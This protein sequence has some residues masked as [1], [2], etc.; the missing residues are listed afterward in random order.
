MTY[1][2]CVLNSY[3]YPY[4]PESTPNPYIRSIDEQQTISGALRNDWGLIPQ[5]QKITQSWSGMDPTFFAQL[6]TIAAIAGTVTL[7]D[8]QGNSYSVY[9][10]PPTYDRMSAAGGLYLNVKLTMWVA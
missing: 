2:Q 8:D 6:N 7:I 4:N 9:V 10:F 5:D 1:T 3:T